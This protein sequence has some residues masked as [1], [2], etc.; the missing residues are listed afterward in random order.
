MKKIFLGLLM[1][2]GVAFG[3]GSKEFTALNEYKEAQKGGMIADR[4]A[5]CCCCLP[6]AVA[7]LALDMPIS[8]RLAMAGI[9]LGN[10]IA[11]LNTNA[12]KRR[13]TARKALTTVIASPETNFNV[14]SEQTF[15]MALADMKNDTQI[16]DAIEK[17]T[18]ADLLSAQTM[19]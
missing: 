18:T 2:P 11:I 17:R 7:V 1:V 8:T 16:N 6:V 13:E 12:Y 14:K 10:G 5:E 3:M 19:Q 4:A 15:A 9:G